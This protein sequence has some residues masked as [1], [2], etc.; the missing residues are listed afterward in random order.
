MK[1]L[2]S[3]LSI[4]CVVLLASCASEQTKKMAQYSDEFYKALES[5]DFSRADQ[6]ISWFEAHDSD[7]SCENALE[8]SADLIDEAMAKGELGDMEGALEASKRA[9]A[10]YD[11]AVKKD[12]D[13]VKELAESEYKSRDLVYTIDGFRQGIKDFENAQQVSVDNAATAPLT[14]GEG[15]MTL[16]PDEEQMEEV[17]EPADITASDLEDETKDQD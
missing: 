5:N 7:L 16:L 4:L 12:A 11:I 9:V 3:I 13:K 1:K 2:L 14:G 8:L 10:F 6:L 15:Q 17:R